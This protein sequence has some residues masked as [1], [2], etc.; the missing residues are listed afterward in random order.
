MP[1]YAEVEAGLQMPVALAMETQRAIRRLLPDPVDDDT[2]LRCIELAMG[3][4]SGGNAQPWEFVV[5][6]DPTV[7]HQLARL[8]RQAWSV[9]R[10]LGWFRIRREA[11]LRRIVDA[12]QWQADHFEEIPVVVV[13]CRRRPVPR[14]W[15]WAEA[16]YYGSVFPTVQNLLLAARALGLGG[17]LTTLP[18]WSMMLARRTLGLPWNVTP[19]AVVPLGWPRGAH[20]PTSRRPVEEVVHLDRFGRRLT[21]ATDGRS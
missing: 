1:S 15:P 16:T 20:G 13:V 5:V 9:Y 14:L 8:N 18:L 3:A 17:T 4:P 10:R 19:C 2:V 6:R 21:R 7:K 12:V 11:R